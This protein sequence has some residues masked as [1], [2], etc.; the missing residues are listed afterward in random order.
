MLRFVL[1][2]FQRVSSLLCSLLFARI[3]SRRSDDNL[4]RTH[5]NWGRCLRWC[6]FR[7]LNAR[8]RADDSLLQGITRNHLAVME[9]PFIDRMPAFLAHVRK[10][11]TSAITASRA[12]IDTK[13]TMKIQAFFGIVQPPPVGSEGGRE[14]SA[15]VSE[16]VKFIFL[17]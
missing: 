15:V 9:P 11:R 10:N 5:V 4:W 17:F 8:R 13:T 2:I 12:R 14:G 16:S 3:R 1:V 7:L 6:H